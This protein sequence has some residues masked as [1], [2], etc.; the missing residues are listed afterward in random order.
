MIISM[1]LITIRSSTPG[2]GAMDGPGDLGVAGMVAF[3][4]GITH[5]VGVIGAGGQVGTMA[6]MAD[7]MDGITAA[8]PTEAVWVD[9]ATDTTK[10][11]LSEPAILLTAVM[12]ASPE[13]RLEAV[14]T[15]LH[16][17]VIQPV[18]SE[19]VTG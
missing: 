8:I 17:E 6:I 10:D 7:I 4:D 18:H 15:A 9:S 1:T 19:G 13:V 12:R 11:I 2:D 16:R 14:R 3:G 5:I